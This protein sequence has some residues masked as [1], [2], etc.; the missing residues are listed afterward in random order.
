M[1]Q[2][3]IGIEVAV[4]AFQNAQSGHD[5]DSLS[6]V[7][8]GGIVEINGAGGHDHHTDDHNAS[9]SQRKDSLEVSHFGF[10]P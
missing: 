1:G 2:D 10:P 3:A 4:V 6:V 9:Q 5:V 8:F 7:D